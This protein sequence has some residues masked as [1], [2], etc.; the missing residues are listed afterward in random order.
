VSLIEISN[1]KKSFSKVFALN[2]VSTNLEAGEQYAIQGSSGSG[3]S[4]LLYLLGGLDR[5]TEGSILIDG[6]N[7]ATYNDEE[8]AKYRNRN[9][10]FVF[11][12]HFLLPSMNCLDNIF[13]PAKIGGVSQVELKGEVENLAERLK[14]SHCLKKYPY[15]LSGGEQQRVNI[16]R[17]LSLKPKIL[18]CD[19]PTG[20][21]DSENSLNVAQI[22]KSLA[23]DF[24]STLVVVTHDGAVANEF[25]NQ[26]F[27]R[28]GMMQ[29]APP[30]LPH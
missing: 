6:K 27:M 14:I 25:D 24:N 28:D 26:L 8:L 16:I 2:G 22:L 21:L 3:K 15:E 4:T 5:P 18:L 23:K 19:E 20:N 17:A 9:V 1:V 7:L 11:Q 29:P 12:F 10:G 30:K 13:L